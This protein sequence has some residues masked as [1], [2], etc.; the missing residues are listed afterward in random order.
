MKIG[1]LIWSLNVKGGGQ[2]QAL[3]LA[4]YLKRRGYKVIFFTYFFDKKNTYQFLVKDLELRFLCKATKKEEMKYWGK[5]GFGRFLKRIILA[6]KIVEKMTKDMNIL[7]IHD[8][9][10]FISAYFAKKKI[11]NL[12]TVYMCNDIPCFDWVYKKRFE[13]NKSFVETIVFF[14]LDK[15]ITKF[16][17]NYFDK[18]LVL[19]KLNK[20]ALK[21]CFNINSEIVISGVDLKEFKFQNKKFNKQENTVILTV[22][23]LEKYKRFEDAI[24]SVNLLKKKGFNCKLIIAGK[25]DHNPSY[26]NHLKNLISE[27]NIRDRII[28]KGEVSEKELKELYRKAD[29]FVF[30]AHNQTWGLVVFE[31]MASGIPV[32]VSNTTGASEVLT[33]MKNALIFN[34]KNYE[35]LARMIELL[36]KNKNIYNRIRLNGRKFVEEKISWEKYGSKMEEIFLDLCKNKNH[37]R[38]PPHT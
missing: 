16:F 21:K 19:D 13:K 28:F 17:L 7:N 3:E 12:K 34:S 20:N 24:L 8:E 23:F 35:E 2:R 31:A 32:I 4:N 11:K 37:R 14:I 36:I 15:I 6:K 10:S 22:G 18:I 9:T 26:F 30:P 25:Y 33:H 1:I 27:L 29:I 38:Q 5:P